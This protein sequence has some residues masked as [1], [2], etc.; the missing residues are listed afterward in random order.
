MFDN[1]KTKTSKQQSKIPEERARY[2]KSKNS[3]FAT[4]DS[5]SMT[6]SEKLQVII[7]KVSVSDLEEG[8]YRSNPSF[9]EK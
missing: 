3:S 8:S 7:P 1:D 5:F 2:A 6:D 4:S 9:R